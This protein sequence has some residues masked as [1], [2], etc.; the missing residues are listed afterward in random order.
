MAEGDKH[1]S[2]V[3]LIQAFP[4]VIGTLLEDVLGEK[5]PPGYRQA[6]R[7]LRSCPY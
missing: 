1:R 7:A 5:P 2:L 6:S 3:D 4:A